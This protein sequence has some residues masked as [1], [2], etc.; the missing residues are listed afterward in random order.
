MNQFGPKTSSKKTNFKLV[1]FHSKFSSFYFISF[2]YYSFHFTLINS[3]AIVLTTICRHHPPTSTATDRHQ[4]PHRPLL[5]TI[6]CRHRLPHLPLFAVVSHHR[7]PPPI[8]ANYHRSSPL[9]TTVSHC[10]PP[11]IAIVH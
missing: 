11:S 9:A 1:L 5:S 6:V 4:W 7:L 10:P 3:F 2:H 8:T